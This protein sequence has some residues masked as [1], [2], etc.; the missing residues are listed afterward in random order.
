MSDEILKRY[1][2][3]VVDTQRKQH[4]LPSMSVYSVR[5]ME[6]NSLDPTLVMTEKL[7]TIEI[8]ESDLD[9]LTD[10]L[11]SFYQVRNPYERQELIDREAYLRKKN[12]AV[13][14][15]WE[16]YKMLLKLAAEGK[17]FD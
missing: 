16:N 14:K 2:M 1:R 11:N 12:P 15:A 6:G 7:L 9:R 10:H 5:D 8:A 13:K 17:T 3:R 4:Y